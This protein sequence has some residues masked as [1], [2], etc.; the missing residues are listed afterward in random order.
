MNVQLIANEQDQ[1]RAQCGKDEPGGMKSLVCRAGKHVANA[2]ADDRSDDAEHDRP[3]ERH[4]HVHHVLRDNARDQPNKYVPDQVKHTFPP[5]S[6]TS[7]SIRP[8]FWRRSEVSRQTDSRFGLC[9]FVSGR[10]FLLSDLPVSSVFLRVL[11]GRGLWL[12][13]HQ[14]TRDHRIIRSLSDQCHLGDQ[15]LCFSD[16]GDDAR[17]RRFRR[18]TNS[19]PPP[20]FQLLLQ[21]KHFLYSTLGR[22]LRG[23][24]VA[25]GWPK[26]DPWVTQTQSQT[27]SQSAEGCKFCAFD[28]DLAKC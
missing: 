16:P 13:D 26:G 23:A 12:S 8:P 18:S 20:I 3:E 14:I 11:C 1:D 9:V 15:R 2:P 19:P 17:C 27:Q 6:R 7:S 22:P 25:L 10:G 21:T 28:F 5:R 4:V 24:W